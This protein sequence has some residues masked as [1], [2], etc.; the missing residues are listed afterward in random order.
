MQKLL[1][2]GWGYSP[3]FDMAR[4]YNPAHHLA[5]HESPRLSGRPGR[6]GLRP[7]LQ[8]GGKLG[9]EEAGGRLMEKVQTHEPIQEDHD[10]ADEPGQ[11]KTQ[12]SV[13]L[14]IERRQ[15]VILLGLYM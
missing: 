2:Q 1:E 7:S 5:A 6:Q 10:P 14:V 4:R 8:P 13:R 3:L 9:H 12:T 11:E 15:V